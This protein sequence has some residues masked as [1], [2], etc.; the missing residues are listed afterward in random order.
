VIGRSMSVVRRGTWSLAAPPAAPASL[1]R[2]R[3]L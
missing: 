2:M 3:Q 1:G